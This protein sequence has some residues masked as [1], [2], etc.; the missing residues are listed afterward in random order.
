MYMTGKRNIILDKWRITWAGFKL[1]SFAALPKSG[2][3][4]LAAKRQ[5]LISRLQEQLTLLANPQYV[6][7]V[8][9]RVDADGESRIVARDQRVRPWWTT[10]ASGRV[11]RSIKHGSKALEFEKGKAAVA[12]P[13]LEELP[14]VIE[15]LISAAQS[16]ELDEALKAI[17]RPGGAKVPKT[18]PMETRSDMEEQMLCPCCGGKGPGTQRYPAAL[19]RGCVSTL[20]DAQGRRA[21]LTIAEPAPVRLPRAQALLS[22]WRDKELSRTHLCS[23]APWS[24]LR[25]RLGSEV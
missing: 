3:D 5:R 16:G 10:D 19:C 1:L 20:V 11:F 18:A 6:R 24:A 14:S 7:Q 9:R 4:P 13:S 22:K 17:S 8:Q 2:N 15:A 21:S 23:P 25:A 12:V